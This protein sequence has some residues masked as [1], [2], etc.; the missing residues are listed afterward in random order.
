MIKTLKY[1][2]K[3]ILFMIPILLGVSLIIFLLSSLIPGTPVD[4]Y[5]NESTTPEQIAKLTE[6]FG[7]NEPLPIRYWNWLVS[8]LQGDLGN[9]F[10]SGQPVAEMIGERIGPTL[11]LAG[12]ALAVSLLISTTLGVLAAWKP[13]S[14]IDYVASGMAFL[15]SG[16]PAFFLGL[17][18]IYL[19]SVRLGIL[20]NSGMYTNAAAADFGDIFRHMI[21]PV[22]VLAVT[23]SGSNI[24][25]TRS[26]MLE[27][28]GEDYILVSRAKGMKRN[29]ILLKHA[30]R[31]A[32]IP[33]VTSAGL[34]V[35]TLVGGAIVTEQLFGWPGMGTLLMTSIKFRD[36]PAIMGITLYIT[37]G[38]MLV[39]LL[40]DIIYG[41]ID[42]RVRV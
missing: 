16:M 32:L 23:L 8:T 34:T 13:Y 12:L 20:P 5:I 31:N 21:Q 24:R 27:V 38:I 17:I 28:L 42:P 3:R 30:F 11:L 9:S 6:K 41:L 7:L 37:I 10:R 14:V 40:V 22:L 18:S 26:A 1:I 2:G 25:Q 39:N 33:I 29:V 19:F 15:G 35:T 4:A 36:Y